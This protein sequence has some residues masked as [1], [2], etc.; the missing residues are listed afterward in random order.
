MKLLK[1][2]KRNVSLK[3]YTTFKIGGKAK[4]FIEVK[5]LNQLIKALKWAQDNQLP[6]FILGN[7]SNVVFS[8]EGYQGLIIKLKNSTFNIKNSSL[9][10]GAG[11]LITDFVLKCI[12]NGI[13]GFEWMAGIPGTL[14][15]AVY[16]NAGAFG[17][18]IKDLVKKVITLDPDTFKIKNYSLSQ[19]KFGYR[20]SIF[21]T[22]KDIIFKIIL[23]AKKGKKEDIKAKSQGYWD[24]KIQHQMFKYPSAGSV[25]KNIIVEE[26]P[27]AKFYD[28]EKQIVKI[29]DQE[30]AVKGGKISAGWF[31]E[32]C[33]LKGMTYGGAKIADFHANVIINFKR[34]K[35]Q[36]V[37]YLIKLMKEKVFEKFGIK[38]EE[39]IIFVK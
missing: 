30:V 21:K 28:P 3:K 15:G 13:K 5:T 2:I 16:G 23:K 25:F 18:E 35:A 36:D 39:E 29:K 4:Y 10:V 32:Q 22:N 1:G 8:D 17:N 24:Y 6:F 11:L 19:C 38:L 12:K 31:I 20:E 27:Y 7:G 34:A 33:N 9:E 37:M 14:G 26:T